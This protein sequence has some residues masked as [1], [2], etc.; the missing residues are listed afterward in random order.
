MNKLIKIPFDKQKGTVATL[1]IVCTV[2]IVLLMTSGCSLKGE[3]E[4]SSTDDRSWIQ[5]LNEA[6][7]DLVPKDQRPDWL[8][9]TIE[10]F[11]TGGHLG[12]PSPLTVFRGLWNEHVV[13]YLLNLKNCGMCGV[14]YENGEEIIW[15]VPG[16]Q[17]GLNVKK[18]ESESNNWVIIYELSL[19]QIVSSRKTGIARLSVKDKYEFPDISHLNDWLSEDIIP[20]RFAALQLP[21]DV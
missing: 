18:F 21:D 20:R 17:D 15:A 12:I 5:K 14:Y 11:E 19:E 3:S 1:C 6:P 13:Y 2:F 8:N 9:E 16:L 4:L 7:V 10:L